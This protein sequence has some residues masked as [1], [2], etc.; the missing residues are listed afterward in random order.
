MSYPQFL[1]HKFDCLEIICFLAWKQNYYGVWYS[2]ETS[3]GFLTQDYE[4]IAFSSEKAATEFIR[5]HTSN[6]RPVTTTIYD[7]DIVKQMI[8]HQQPLSPCVMLE[9]WN[10]AE[11][12]SGSVNASFLGEL[13]DDLT[14][15]IYD[16][17]FY[18]NNLP[19]INT[20]GQIYVPQFTDEEW[21][22]LEDILSDA[23]FVITNIFKG[24]RN[25]NG[26][27]SN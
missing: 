9:F 27:I 2:D 11:D 20:S 15:Q 25:E 5:L 12:L 10:I 23:I 7:L 14:N 21:Q 17:L 13:K 18:G 3:D 6:R 16:K 19:E 4:L 24:S 26:G 8:D 22:K 1:K